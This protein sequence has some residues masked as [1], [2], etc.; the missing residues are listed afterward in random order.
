MR[1]EQRSLAAVLSVVLLP[2]A[3]LPIAAGPTLAQSPARAAPSDLTI[4]DAWIRWLPANLPAAGYVRIRNAGA[5]PATLIGAAS[6]AY[7]RVSLH[8]SAEQGGRMQ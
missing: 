4:E 5:A 3:W 7:T 6:P 8:R 2:F 1:F